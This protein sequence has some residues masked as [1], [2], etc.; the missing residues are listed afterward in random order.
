MGR[1]K[2]KR[3]TAYKKLKRVVERN[4]SHNTRVVMDRKSLI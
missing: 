2:D 3:R 1:G 4:E